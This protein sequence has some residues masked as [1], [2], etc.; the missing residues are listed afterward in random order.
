MTSTAA[1]ALADR[2]AFVEVGTTNVAELEK[3]NLALFPI[4]YP[5]QVY[6]DIVTCSG[7]SFLATIDDDRGPGAAARTIGGVACRLEK[8]AKV[9]G[10]IL[11]IITLGVLAPW[12]NAGL[13]S[14]LLERVLR[15]VREA[16][17]EVVLARLHV[18]INNSEARDFYAKLGFSCLGV[19]KLY[20]KRL[21]PP[22]AWVLARPFTDEGRE[23][24]DR[25]RATL[26]PA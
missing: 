9:D 26:D 19:S 13:G 6:Q 1:N 12:R 20:Y 15:T 23:A 7:V 17:P 24:L 5:P 16:L 8:D 4:K 22:D 21:E 18:Q 3:I 11:Y 25:I 10:P 2:V 14:A